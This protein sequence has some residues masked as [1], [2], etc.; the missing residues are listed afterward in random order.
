MTGESLTAH[1]SLRCVEKYA[2][3]PPRTTSGGPSPNRGE[4]QFPLGHSSIHTNERY[5]GIQQ[6]L[7][8]AAT[9]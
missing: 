3:A 4:I 2:T 7:N 8:R 5:L 9:A 1:S 6:D